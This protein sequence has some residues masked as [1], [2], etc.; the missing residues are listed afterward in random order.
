MVL[1]RS[2]LPVVLCAA[3]I[4]DA[5][6]AAPLVFDRWGTSPILEPVQ[7]KG[8]RSYRP[9]GTA[10]ADAAAT[11]QGAAVSRA[12]K[13]AQCMATWDTG[14]HITKAKWREICERQIDER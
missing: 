4:G 2:F 3:Q 14:T 1:A 7:R 8:T 13:M 9:E 12:E 5:A 6:L 11:A 10:P